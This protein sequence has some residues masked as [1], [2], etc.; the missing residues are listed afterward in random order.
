MLADM[1][2]EPFE[3]FP[4]EFHIRGETHVAFIVCGI[5]HVNVKVLKIWFPVGGQHF[6]EEFNVMTGCYLITN[7]TDYF[8]VG[9]GSKDRIYH[10]SAKHLVVYVAVDMFHQLSVKKSGVGFQDHKGN[11]CQRTENIP[12]FKTLFRQAYGFCHTFKWENR[13]KPA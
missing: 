11:L 10:D 2:I 4:E 6:L 13:V 7:G 12:A 1:P 3:T 8:G 5:G 9:Y